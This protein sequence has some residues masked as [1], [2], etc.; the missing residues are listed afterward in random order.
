MTPNKA[1]HHRLRDRSLRDEE[2]VGKYGDDQPFVEK[3]FQNR[4]GL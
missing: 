4:Q 3:D 1:S 2:N